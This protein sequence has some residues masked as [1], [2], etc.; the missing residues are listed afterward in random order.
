MEK[1]EADIN[2]KEYYMINGIVLFLF[3]CVNPDIDNT[4][5]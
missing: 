3:S 2:I 4:A 5:S 1:R